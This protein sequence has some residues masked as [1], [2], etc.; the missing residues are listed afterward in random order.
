LG[1][2]LFTCLVVE[3]FSCLAVRNR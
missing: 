1:V 2:E 3:L